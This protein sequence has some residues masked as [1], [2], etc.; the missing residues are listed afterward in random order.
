MRKER[1]DCDNATRRALI[2]R[3]YVH[4]KHSLHF[5]VTRTRVENERERRRGNIA[6][7]AH[8]AER[9]ETDYG[10]GDDGAGGRFRV[11]VQG[12]P[13]AAPG[14]HAA[15]AE[16]TGVESRAEVVGQPVLVRMEDVVQAVLQHVEGEEA[17]EADGDRREAA[18]HRLVRVH[19]EVTE[20]PGAAPVTDHRRRGHER[21]EYRV[22]DRE[23]GVVQ[24]IRRLGVQA[25]CH[26]GTGRAQIDHSHAIRIELS[27]RAAGHYAW[28]A[29]S[30]SP[31]ITKEDLR[32]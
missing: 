27:S 19:V 3:T 7:R 1:L 6:D 29:L 11:D 26:P 8:D 15:Q 23:D 2:G 5:E 16:H 10:R 20:L 17:G 31:A 12:L 14:V 32:A 9:E 25:A 22:Q 28:F 13:G 4:A 30:E 24:T 18:E 21:G